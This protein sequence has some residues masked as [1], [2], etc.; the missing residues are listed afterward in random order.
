MCVA[1][2]LTP[3]QIREKFDE[4]GEKYIFVGYIEEPKSYRLF[5]PSTN[6]FLISRYVVFDEMAKWN[7]KMEKSSC[8][9]NKQLLD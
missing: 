1:Y 2:P 7:E 9:K 8:M 3:S 5:N 6:K 4:K